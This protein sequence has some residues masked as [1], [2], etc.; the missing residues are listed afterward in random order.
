MKVLNKTKDNV[1]ITLGAHTL[2]W[3]KM[4]VFKSIYGRGAWLPY[5]GRFT[6][7]RKMALLHLY[8]EDLNKTEKYL[9]QAGFRT[10]QI[11]KPDATGVYV[12]PL[13]SDGYAFFISKY[14]VTKWLAERKQLG[15]KLQI[16]REK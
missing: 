13:K 3:M 2:N 4:S 11:N 12:Y 8:A 14:S 5:K 15:Q 1:S 6:H 9:N 16:L 10:T 7:L